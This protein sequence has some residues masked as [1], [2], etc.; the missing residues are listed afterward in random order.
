M[1]HGLLAAYDAQLREAVETSDFDDVRTDGPLWVA[2]MSTR[3]F[4]TYRSLASVS[5]DELTALITRTVESFTADPDIEE[6]EWKTRDHDEPANLGSLLVANGLRPQE[7]ETVMAGRIE[8]LVGDDM[9]PDGVTLH[10]V[11]DRGDLLADVER[12][13][14]FQNS[15]FGAIPRMVEMTMRRLQNPSVTLWFA[16][17]GDEVVGSGRLDRVP[18]TDFAG[19]WGGAI[20][21]DWR[22]RGI[23]RALTQARAREA[24]ADGAKY[25]YADCTVMSRVI[26]AA[27]GM[28]PITTTVPYVW[29]RG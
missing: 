26:L 4:V 5:P 23:Y 3:G 6:F 29:R 15:V 8:R 11:G 28:I 27:C 14:S 9:P 22:G 17:A 2:R 25:L 10:R 13:V 7:R 18:G 24:R 12:V 1:R 20:R 16:E 19:L 21:E